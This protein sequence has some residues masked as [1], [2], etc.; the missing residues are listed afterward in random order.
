[1]QSRLA[2]LF[3]WFLCVGAGIIAA[4]WML[5]ALLWGSSRAWS[6]AVAF[7]QLGNAATGGSGNETIS[8]R[9]WRCRTAWPY[10]WLR[11]FIDWMMRLALGEVNHCENAYADER[12]ALARADKVTAPGGPR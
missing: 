7:D 5:L 8:S 2:M 1:M 4:A 6:I 3:L 12:A 9:T 10:S 11:P